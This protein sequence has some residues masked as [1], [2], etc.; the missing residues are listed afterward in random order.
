[1]QAAKNCVTETPQVQHE[2]V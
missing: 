1:M 2:P